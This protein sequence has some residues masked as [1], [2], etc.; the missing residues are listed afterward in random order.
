MAEIKTLLDEYGVVYE[1][2]KYLPDNKHKVQLVETLAELE[3]NNC[4]KTRTYPKTRLHRVTGIKQAIYRAD[5]DRTSG[6]RLHIQFDKNTNQLHLK[7]VVKGQ[8]HDDVIRVIKAK[9]YKYT[10]D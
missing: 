7:D 8:L 1:A 2:N 3:D 5:I 4:H 9:K 6:W 10:D